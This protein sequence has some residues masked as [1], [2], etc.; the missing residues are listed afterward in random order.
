M[1]SRFMKEARRMP[2]RQVRLETWRAVKHAIKRAGGQRK[3]ARQLDASREMFWLARINSAIRAVSMS[4]EAENELRAALGLPSLPAR[5]EVEV[6]ARCG[7]DVHH[8]SC[9]GAEGTAAWVHPDCK[10]IA[11]PGCGPRP[12]RRRTIQVTP[13]TFERL[14]R[15]KDNCYHRTWDDYFASL[16]NA[17]PDSSR[18]DT[19]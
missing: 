13:E 16:L 1:S 6:C 10:I 11:K 12:R 15:D 14:A 17:M 9:D 19:G 8:T 2:A 18:V 7:K 3:L 4:L 5:K